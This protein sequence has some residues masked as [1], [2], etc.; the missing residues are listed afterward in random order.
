MGLSRYKE[1]L[2]SVFAGSS[3][4][5]KKTSV[6]VLG[7]STTLEVLTIGSLGTMGATTGAMLMPASTVAVQ[8]LDLVGL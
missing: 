4:K 1:K 8:A 7:A 2:G 5:A 3:C 6:Y